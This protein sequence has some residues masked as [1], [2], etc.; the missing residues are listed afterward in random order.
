MPYL[1]LK[2]VHIVSFTAWFA[3]M[4]YVWRLYVYIVEN[5]SNDVKSQLLEMSRKLLKIIMRP[6]AFLTLL[7][8]FSMFVIQWDIYKTQF[9]IW[10]KLTF[11]FGLL[12]HHFLAEYYR[13]QLVA[14]VVYTSRFF[15]IM[16]ELPTLAL[17]VVVTLVIYKPF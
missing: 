13:K 8:G 2:V 9:W 6:A 17:I 1:L 14:K 7:S 16:N 11:V 5:P 10:I 3:G 4:F 15:R 12:I